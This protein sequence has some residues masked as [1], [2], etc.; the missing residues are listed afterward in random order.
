[1]RRRLD[2]QFFRRH[3]SEWDVGRETAG[4]RTEQQREHFQSAAFRRHVDRQL[5]WLDRRAAAETGALFHVA[6]VADEYERRPDDVRFAVRFE[7]H[8]DRAVSEPRPRKT[9]RERAP[10]AA[11]LPL[12][13]LPL[14]DDTCIE[15]GA[16]VVDE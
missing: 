13:Y 2:R 14:A 5:P 8:G 11:P 15:A 3:R 12:R 16:G 6:A 4:N 10:L 1:M 9:D 7:T